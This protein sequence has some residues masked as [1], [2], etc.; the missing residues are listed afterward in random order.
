VGRTRGEVLGMNH[1]P[2][3]LLYIR[4][5]RSIPICRRII[6]QTATPTQPEN[7]P[8]ALLGLESPLIRSR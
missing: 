4:I 8:I 7:S 2:T 1:I 3:L 5:R 6:D